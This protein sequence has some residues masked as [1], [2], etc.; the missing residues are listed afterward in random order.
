MKDRQ[1]LLKNENAWKVIRSLAIPSCIITLVMAVYN[2]AD[3]FFIGKTGN[4]NMVNAIAVCMPVFTI[5]QAFGTLVG[6]GGCTAISLALGRED[7][8]KCRQ[9][10]SFAFWFCLVFG[11]FLAVGTNLAVEPLLTFLGVSEGSREFAATYLRILSVGCP[12][13]MFSNSFVNLLRADGSVK[14]SIVANLSGTF[15]NMILDPIMILVFNMGVGGAAVATVLGNLTASIVV[16]AYLQKKTDTLSIHPKDLSFRP[17]ITWR[18]LLLGLPLASGTLIMSFTYMLMNNLL[19]KISP[20]AQG[21]FGICRSLMLF[22]TMIQMGICVGV[23]PAV[24]YNY[25][26]KNFR[27][28]KEFILK[29]GAVTVCFGAIVAVACIGF[30]E[31]LLGSFI[32][33]PAIISYGRVI[34]VGCFCTAPVY[35]IYQMAVT[36]LQAIEQPMWSTVITVLRQGGIIMPAM[37]LLELV[38]GFEGLAFSFAITDVIAAL[39]GGVLLGRQ[40]KKI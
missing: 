16:F 21:A 25:G 35:G 11:A 32:D 4:T 12:V 13:M 31:V 34:L 30:R 22:S 23:Q 24:S 20:D 26:Q 40:L 36:F 6:M 8:K 38:F 27:R 28:V 15:V 5:I 39:V 19:L 9:I 17:D 33:S 37:L 2:M 14:E 10:S 18:T 1:N 7:M 29:T 3:V